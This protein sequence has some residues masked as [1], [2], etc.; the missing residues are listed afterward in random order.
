MVGKILRLERNC[1]FIKPEDN[2]PDLFFHG[3]ARVNHAVL[4]VGDVVSF[5]V[6]PAE[7]EQRRRLA[8]NIRRLSVAWEYT[9]APPKRDIFADYV[10][11]ASSLN[12]EIPKPSGTVDE[13]NL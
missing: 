12:P 2:S 10:K 11:Y 13:M 5:D 4:L 6:Q 1:G 7:S 9:P 3:S 8:I